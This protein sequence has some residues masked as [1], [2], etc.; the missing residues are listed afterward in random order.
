MSDVWDL[1]SKLFKASNIF[2]SVA[3]LTTAYLRYRVS[4]KIRPNPKIRPSPNFKNDF[5]ISPTLKVRP[6]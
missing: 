3:Y 1:S 5:N 6:R 2:N 4:P